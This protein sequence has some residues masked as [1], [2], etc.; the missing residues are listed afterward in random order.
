MPAP[1]PPFWTPSL[2]TIRQLSEADLALGRLAG[3]GR[4][5][6]NPHLLI[7]PFLRREA[8]LSS[9]IEG[10]ITQL[11]QLFLFDLGME[12]P[13]NRD[14]A[15]EVA[16]YVRALELGLKQVDEGVPLGCWL[17]RGLHE[18]LMQG[19]RGANKRPGEFRPCDV[20]IG[21]DGQGMADARFVPPPHPNVPLLLEDLERFLR[22]PGNF[23]V[24]AQVA[25]VHYQFET[26][27]PFMDGNGRLGRLLITLMLCER[28]VLPLP[29]LYLSVYLERH[30]QEYKDHMLN[31]SRRGAW[32]QWFRFFAIGVASQA[33][34]AT[35]R[36]ELLMDLRETHREQARTLSRSPA[37][38]YLVDALYEAPYTTIG[39][40]A[41][42]MGVG[43]PPAR[44][45]V[46]RLVQAG[47]LVE[48][49]GRLRNRFYVAREILRLLDAELPEDS[50]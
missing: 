18:Q 35:R 16:N 30:D 36:A 5:L 31:V 12:E 45:A 37:I 50:A 7:Q 22:N 1:L 48:A 21:R 3:V 38:A 20:M 4:S 14:D 15:I 23:P 42:V 9:R 26:I 34:D 40:A 19:A 24:V 8:V 6:P 47:I 13:P 41:T 46:E 17:L 32:D 49:S 25:M 27:H 39:R 33:R 43:E 44:Q 11:G 29:L 28:K 10:T 2:E